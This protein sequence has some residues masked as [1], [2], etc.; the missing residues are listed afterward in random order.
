MDCT[1]ETVQEQTA[2]LAALRRKAK[3]IGLRIK[4]GFCPTFGRD[5]YMLL[6]IE[7]NGLIA[8]GRPVPYSLSFE[9]LEDEIRFRT[10]LQ[11]DAGDDFNEF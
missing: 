3:K 8:G 4:K 2:R 9:E 6:D 7:L 1:T 10:E 5:G 11:E